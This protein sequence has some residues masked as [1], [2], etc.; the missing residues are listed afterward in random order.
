MKQSV[1]DMYSRVARL[2]SGLIADILSDVFN[3]HKFLH[4]DTGSINLENTTVVSY[5][6]SH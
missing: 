4:G 1:V 6:L 3:T 5:T 2:V